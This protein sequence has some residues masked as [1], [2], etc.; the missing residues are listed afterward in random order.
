[1]S[2]NGGTENFANRLSLQ[3]TDHQGILI[4]S[5]SKNFDVRYDARFNIGKYIRIREDAH[6]YFGQSRGANTNDAYNG[7][8]WNA[9]GMPRSAEAYYSDGT[10]GGTAPKDPAYAAQYGSNFADIYG[11]LI[12]PV[13][14]L[15]AS[16]Q[17]RGPVNLHTST[18]FEITEPIPGLRYTGRLSY[19]RS[20][21]FDKTF[22]PRRTEPGKP[23]LNNSLEYGAGISTWWEIENR[24][25]YDRSFGKHSLGLMAAT[26]AN[27]SRGKSFAVTGRNLETE[28]AFFRYLSY[29]S[30]YD[31]PTDAYTNPDNNVSVVGS[32]TYSWNNRYFATASFRRD[33]AGRLPAG[34][35]YGDFPAV[36]AAW[37]LS[38]EAFMPK[39]DFLT[40]LKLR[41]G[42]GRIGNLST[43]G[44]ASGYEMLRIWNSGQQGGQVGIDNP[45]VTRLVANYAAFNPYLTWETSE[46]TDFGVDINLLNDRFAFTADYFNKKTYNLIKDRQI[47]WTGMIG[48]DPPKINEGEI[49]NTGWEFSAG[50]NDKAGEVNYH[51]NAN[52]STLNNRLHYIGPIDPMT[53]E[54]PTWREGDT[55]RGGTLTPFR[56]REGDPL[57][58]YWLVETAGLFQSDAEAAAYVDKDGK[59][60]QPNAVAGDLK[61]IDQNGDGQI[62]DDDRVYMGSYFPKLTYGLNAGFTWKNLSLNL[63]LQGVGNTRIFHAFKLTTLNESI[64]NFNRWDRIQDAWPKTNDIPRISLFDPNNNFSTNSD[65][66]LENGAYMRIKNLNVS[67]DLSSLMRRAGHFRDR[68]S[69]LSVYASVDNLYTFTR[70]TGMDPEVGQKGMD[71]GR[72]PVPRTVSFGIRLTY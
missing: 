54:K 20:S 21:Y 65:W 71:S 31:S 33:Y 58:S 43:V 60:I 57:Y 51:V 12:N 8:I 30:S 46:Q 48:V 63:L 6:W 1:M 56:T 62:N 34:N 50:W 32:A 35:K 61:F 17:Y 68:Q 69:L 67:Y 7:V 66:Y 42:W 29:A 26:T 40:L 4:G 47:G 72:Y 10:F 45:L 53:G 64:G 11:D 9:L 70:Y 15:T 18:F 55:Y 23:D 49:R 44:L 38:E 36:T 28:D 14:E 59:R 19:R 2:I 41:G 25:N 27:E 24:L 52:L 22:N 5:Y 37:K 39:S 3:Y 13:R 16:D